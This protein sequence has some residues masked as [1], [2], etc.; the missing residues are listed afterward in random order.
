MLKVLGI[1]LLSIGLVISSFLGA[2]HFQIFHPE[3]AEAEKQPRIETVMT[4]TMR[5]PIMSDN[6]AIGY[7]VLDLSIDYDA[8]SLGA[9]ADNFKDVAVDE[10]FRTVYEAVGVD[11][12]KAKKTDLTG[13][14]KELGERLNRRLGENLVREVRVKEFMFVPPR[15]HSS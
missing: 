13:L 12:K 1:A 5:V 14:L 8:A 11:F 9:G 15:K 4:G 10:T 7:A 3:S 2:D 6:K